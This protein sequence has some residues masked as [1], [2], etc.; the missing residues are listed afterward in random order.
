MSTPKVYHFGA[1]I[2]RA[3]ASSRLRE[4]FARRDDGLPRAPHPLIPPE[5]D[6]DRNRLDAPLLFELFFGLSEILFIL[7]VAFPGHSR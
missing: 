2:S 4:A 7:S 6:R 5:V 1:S 3:Q